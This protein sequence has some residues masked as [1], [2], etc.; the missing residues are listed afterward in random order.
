L[1]E[2]LLENGCDIRYLEKEGCFPLEITVG[3]VSE[4]KKGSGYLF[5]ETI[6][7]SAKLSSQYVSSILLSAPYALNPVDLRI[8]GETVSQPYIDMTISV[9][10]DFGVQV[11]DN[12]KGDLHAYYI[13]KGVYRN[14]PEY[15]VESDASSAS[16]PLAMAAVTGGTVTVNNIGNAFLLSFLGTSILNENGISGKHSLQGDA[17]FYR[18]LES[19]GCN[20]KQTDTSTTVTGPIDGI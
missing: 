8:K 20:V 9:M 14:P 17:N 11:V 7:L 15:T 6:N 3:P 13:P 4:N 10:K 18:V 12:S 16:Y 2:A 19:M 5:G 1:V